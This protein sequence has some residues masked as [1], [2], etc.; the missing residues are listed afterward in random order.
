MP[1][2]DSIRSMLTGPRSSTSAD[3][4]APIDPVHLAACTLLLDVAY[5]D[6][7]FTA[8]ERTHLESVLGRHF[9]LDAA[10]GHR[11]I[12]LA[13]QERARSVDYFQFT[14][15]LQR[16]YD[17]GQKMVLAE[18]MWGLVLADGTVSDREQYL[19]R[20]IANLL[21]LEPGYLAQAKSAAAGARERIST[22]APPS[23]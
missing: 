11:L 21:D 1:F 6:G 16:E 17:T 15:V 5:A 18:I 19:T 9:G 10:A 7:E 20:K 23:P 22:D 3:E 2:L 12:E 13:E 4:S 8:P 14:S